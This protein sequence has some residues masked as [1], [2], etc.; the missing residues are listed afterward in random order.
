MTT[1]H[2]TGMR[3]LLLLLLLM[4]MMMMTV[5]L[6][7]RL[8]VVGCQMILRRCR[9]HALTAASETISSSLLM[10]ASRSWKT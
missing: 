6:L 5:T 10:P 8:F 4:M 7:S 1:E 2:V 9:L 3:L